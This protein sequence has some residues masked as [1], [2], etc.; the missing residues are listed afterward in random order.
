MCRGIGVYAYKSATGISL[1]ITKIIQYVKTSF[2]K[3]AVFFSTL[4]VYFRSQLVAQPG[5]KG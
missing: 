4:K 3:P 2:N 1:V 5:R